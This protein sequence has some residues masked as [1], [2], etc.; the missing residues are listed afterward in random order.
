MNLQHAVAVRM[1]DWI[2]ENENTE[3]EKAFV[4][5]GVEV[6]LNEFSK[7]IVALLLGMLFRIF[8]VVFF[9]TVF[10][11]L[12]R[13]YAAGAHFQNN[14]MCFCF[15]ECVLVVIP[16]IVSVANIHWSIYALLCMAAGM[17]FHLS[18]RERRYTAIVFGMGMVV[19]CILGGMFFLK[20]TIV[21]AMIVALSTVYGEKECRK[22]AF[23]RTIF[24][25]R[26]GNDE[27]QENET[28]VT[29]FV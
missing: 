17:C 21:I 20:T 5:Y 27:E 12:L 9:E 13:R 10:L 1:S 2:C 11:I 7:M 15:T 4:T 18:A 19:S 23:C 25:K 8:W 28:T 29:V 6:F 26:E 22:E 24:G 3:E 14:A 16:V